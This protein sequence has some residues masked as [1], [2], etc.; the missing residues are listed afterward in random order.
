MIIDET[1]IRVRYIETDRMGYVYYGHYAQFYEVGR[2]EML[3]GF[4][5]TYKQLEEDGYF[6]PVADL[7]INYL[8]PA[9]YDDL[10]T[11]KTFL[12]KK[13]LIKLEFEYEVY[14]QE[15]VLLNTGTTLLIFVDAQTRKPVK[16]PLYFLE[17]I[18]KYF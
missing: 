3:R 1:K 15:N 9:V 18:E 14:N 2:T 6:L 11:V 17:K 4:G 12:K 5:I 7:N 8:K 10:L 13:P 16:A